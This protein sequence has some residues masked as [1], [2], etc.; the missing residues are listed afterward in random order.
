MI[1]FI[2]KP[3]VTHAIALIAFFIICFVNGNMVSSIYDKKK[4]VLFTTMMIVLGF[5]FGVMDGYTF[6][7][8]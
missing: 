3:E 1:D 5:L 8:I 2:A 4:L 7:R 6:S